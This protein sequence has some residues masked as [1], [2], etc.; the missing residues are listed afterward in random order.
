MSCILEYNAQNKITGVKNA[1]GKTSALFNSIISNPHL[2]VE[3]SVEIYKNIFSF[4]H[5]FYFFS[6][7]SV[8]G[9]KK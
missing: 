3:Q 1:E 5:C 2:S 7:L 8:V 9:R 4:L 6:R